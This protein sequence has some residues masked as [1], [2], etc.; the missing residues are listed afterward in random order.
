MRGGTAGG[1]GNGRLGGGRQPGKEGAGAGEGRLPGARSG[2]SD[3]GAHASGPSSGHGPLGTPVPE[4]RLHLSWGFFRASPPLVS[5]P[6]EAPPGAT[7]VPCQ[8]RSLLATRAPG[9]GP[10]ERGR[11]GRGSARGLELRPPPPRVQRA[12]ARGCS[13]G[14]RGEEAPP[15]PSVSPSPQPWPLPICLALP[16]MATSGR[17]QGK[18]YQ[19][20]THLPA[21]HSKASIPRPN[22]NGHIPYRGLR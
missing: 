20:G 14:S 1:S 22:H 16:G 4:E 10:S 8:L 19:V 15:C 18:D 17:Y 3:P 2:W 7:S 21:L 6:P 13:Q 9:E 12:K 5:A 11:Q